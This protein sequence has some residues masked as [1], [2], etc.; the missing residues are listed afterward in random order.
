[1]LD[2]RESAW[3]PPR[4]TIPIVSRKIVALAGTD[5]KGVE[6]R[7][8]HMVKGRGRVV[9][10]P[11]AAQSF[12]E[13]EVRI[14]AITGGIN[15]APGPQRPG[16]VQKDLTFEFATWPDV[17]TIYVSTPSGEVQAIVKLNGKDITGTRIKFEEGHDITGLE[18]VFDRPLRP[19]RPEP[20]VFK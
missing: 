3:P 2:V 15:G 18:I 4:G 19:S 11:A 10:G 5:L 8:T 17:G 6:V 9:V 13:H 14:A 7:P 12:K 16:V 20:P 1:M